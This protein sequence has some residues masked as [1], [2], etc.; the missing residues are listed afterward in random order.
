[1]AY[2]DQT[3]APFATRALPVRRIAQADLDWA[4]AEGWKDF[5]ARRGDVLLLP[6]VYTVAGLLAAALCLN[7]TFL[8]FVFPLMAGVSILGP[9]AA[10][11]FYELARRREQNLPSDWTHFLDPLRGRGRM[12]LALLTLGLLALFAAWVLI[13]AL[14]HGQ[15]LGRLGS[16]GLADF[17]RDMVSTP[18]GWAL[19]IAGNLAGF[20][21]AVAAL[22]LTMVS[23]PMIVDKPASAT[24][25]VLTSI[26]AARANPAAVAGWGLRVA[27]LLVLGSLPLFAALPVVIPVL[28]YATWHL[29]TRLVVR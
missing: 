7:E 1:M 20:I 11:G 2:A 12:K 16:L 17:F 27:G 24:T 19:I 28:G 15:T 14:I 25:A 5:R 21:F 9:A 29:Y 3:V 10:V 13:A 26:R 23:F 8:P 4:L 22:V 18:Q 6:I